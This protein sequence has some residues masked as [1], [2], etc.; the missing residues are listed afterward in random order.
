MKAFYKSI[1]ALLIA[2]GLFLSPVSAREVSVNYNLSDSV[3]SGRVRY[4]SQ[5]G[6]NDYYYEEYW[7]KFASYSSQEC[8][9]AC[10][11]MALSYLGIDETPEALGDYWIEK[12]YTQ[13][14]PFS[15]VFYDVPGA[16][17]GHSFDFEAAYERYEKGGYSPVIIYFT[18]ELNPYKTG[19][20]HFV[21]IVDKSGENEYIAID[22]ASDEIRNVTIEKTETGTLIVRT[23][24]KDGSFLSG[25]ETEEELCSAQYKADGA[26]VP[27]KQ[28]KPSEKPE[29]APSAPQK[30][31]QP[32]PAVKEPEAVT[33][34][35]EASTETKASEKNETVSKKPY[36]RAASLLT[37][38]IKKSIAE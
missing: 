20:R 16:T 12:G 13:G 38:A 3:E 37:A 24:A 30:T 29:K 1:S 8:G 10:I 18:R 28:E 15:T 6:N 9:T 11:S 2:L 7:G 35:A 4:V 17:G 27:E 36:N 5:I 22:P 32:E 33:D 31:A 21:M 25:E 26:Y 34:K 19:N 23:Q 14:E